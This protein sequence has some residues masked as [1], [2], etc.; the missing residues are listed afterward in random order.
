MGNGMKS[1]RHSFNIRYIKRGWK[2]FVHYQQRYT[3]FATY[4]ITIRINQYWLD[5]TYRQSFS[6]ARDATKWEMI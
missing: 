6:R 2:T 1:L 3:L 5:H 4:N